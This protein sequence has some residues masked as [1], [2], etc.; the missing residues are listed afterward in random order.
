MH[1]FAETLKTSEHATAAKSEPCRPHL[2]QRHDVDSVFRLQRAVGNQVVLRLLAARTPR[3]LLEAEG[4]EQRNVTDRAAPPRFGHDF[5]SVRVR[6]GVSAAQS[7]EAVHAHTLTTGRDLVCGRGRYAPRTR[8]AQMPLAHELAH[9]VQQQSGS[10]SRQLI[11]RDLI[12]YGQITWNDFHGPPPPIDPKTPQPTDREGAGVRSIFDVLPTYS[13]VTDASP[14]KP[15]KKC[16]TGKNRSTEH[17]A[18]AQPD[19]DSFQHPNAQM[20]QDQSWTRKLYKTGDGTD[21]CAEKV[22][23]C[24]AAFAASKA[25]VFFNGTKI[26]KKEECRTLMVPNCMRNDAPKERTRLLNHEQY[27]FNI[28]N[29]LANNAKADLKARGATLHV[30]AQG[31]GNDAA[32]DAARDEYNKQVDDALRKPSKAWLDAKNKAQDDYDTET[33]HGS[34]QAKQSAWETKVKDGLKGYGP[35]AATPPATTPAPSPPPPAATKTGREPG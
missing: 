25:G 30:T 20:D 12:P 28:T 11:Q 21:Y 26:T 27:H 23:K 29:V 32:R 22:P 2:A 1:A 16:G 6:T 19:P 35:P 24:E 10:V 14:T 17:E 34:D 9:V 4:D 15:A 8:E 18:T 7:A 33:G 13:P 31:C 5:S 3:R